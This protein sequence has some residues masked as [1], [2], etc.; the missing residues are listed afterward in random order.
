M[1]EATG[2]KADNTGTANTVI[3]NQSMINVLARVNGIN[4][5]DNIATGLIAS[6]AGDSITIA[7]SV[8]NTTASATGPGTNTATG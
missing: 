8:V 2:V 7:N 4:S 3:I 1:N 5:G 6:G